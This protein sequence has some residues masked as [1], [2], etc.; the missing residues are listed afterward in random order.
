M[1]NLKYFYEDVIIV[2]DYWTEWF[3][4]K[5]SITGMRWKIECDNFCVQKSKRNLKAWINK[6]KIE[7]NG[8]FL[9]TDEMSWERKKLVRND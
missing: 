9:W 7:R 8:K 3:S 6:M 5:D 2:Y 4:K 1:E